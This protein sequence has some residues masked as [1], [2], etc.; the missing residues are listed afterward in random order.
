[1]SIPNSLSSLRV[2]DFNGDSR[3]DLFSYNPANGETSVTLLSGMRTLRSSALFSVPV[4]DA[5][6]TPQYGDFNGDGKTD[7]FWRTSRL[8]QNGIW[9]IDGTTV[10]DAQFVP[11][12]PGAWESVMGEFNGDGKSDVF[13]YK[14]TTG[15]YRVWLM[16]G[17]TRTEEITGSAEPG[18]QPALADFNNDQFTDLF[19]RNA[20]TGE[21]GVWIFEQGRPVD[22]QFVPSLAPTWTPQVIDF[23]GDGRSDV[24][25]RDRVTGQNQVWL[26]STTSVQP[27]A[28]PIN[29]PGTSSDLVFQIGDFNGDRRTDFLVRNPS[30]GTNQ[31]WESRE[32]RVEI[33]EIANQAAEFLPQIGDFNGDR[34]SDIRWTKP[35][36][37]DL[38]IW[39]SDG[40]VPR[41]MM[42]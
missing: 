41:A 4:A 31:I 10:T 15:E 37:T 20:T 32:T 12:L 14:P 13:W 29:L 19:W 21:N 18:W 23:N 39:F 16:D 1:M 38:T 27:T 17:V 22:F 9:L 6:E 5:W 33:L 40:I 7:L 34:F 42:A 11:Q 26:W 2:P 35:G 24:L 8:G 36:T 30:T 25:W 28:T 3:T